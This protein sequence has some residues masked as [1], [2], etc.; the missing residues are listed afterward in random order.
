MFQ[1]T[2]PT[3]VQL[4]LKTVLLVVAQAVV[5]RTKLAVP[6]ATEWYLW[7]LWFRLCA[8]TCNRHWHRMQRSTA[9]P[10]RLGLRKLKQ[11]QPPPTAQAVVSTFWRKKIS[12]LVLDLHKTL[13]TV[14]GSLVSSGGHDTDCVVRLLLTQ[15]IYDM[16]LFIVFIFALEAPHTS[17]SHQ[18]DECRRK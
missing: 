5:R 2:R 17:S 14:A 16:K 13:P 7:Y 3:T 1:P 15:S 18:K 6:L 8:R 10:A 12:W 4:A 9:N 11:Q